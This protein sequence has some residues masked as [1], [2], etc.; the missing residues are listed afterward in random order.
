MTD[1]GQT[2]QNPAVTS[3]IGQSLILITPQVEITHPG[4]SWHSQ[5]VNDIV[6]IIAKFPEIPVGGCHPQTNENLLHQTTGYWN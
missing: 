6:S 5:L 1:K 2:N 4:K 3:T